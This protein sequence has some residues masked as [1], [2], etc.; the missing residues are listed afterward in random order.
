MAFGDEVFQ[1]IELANRNRQH[2]HH[3][4]AGVDR[5]G[6]EVWRED[7][8]VPARDNADREIEADD[9]V[10]GEHQRRRQSRE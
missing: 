6:Y 10:D 4:E 1:V 2:Q 5:A 8:G 7:S 3:G 9:S